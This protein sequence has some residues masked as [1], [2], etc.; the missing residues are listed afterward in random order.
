MAVAEDTEAQVGERN[1]HDE[2]TPLLAGQQPETDAPPEYE[3][4]D[5]EEVPEKKGRKIGWYIW[6]GFW[7]V[8][9]ALFLALFIKGWIDAGGDVDVSSLFD[10]R[11]HVS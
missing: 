9:A 11:P 1:A 7:V 6:R 5:E 10:T 4:T 8:L 3:D 2:Q